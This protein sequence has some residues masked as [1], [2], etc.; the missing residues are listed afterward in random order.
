MNLE[1]TLLL[2][3]CSAATALPCAA[4]RP[5]PAGHGTCEVL[6]R[7]VLDA[8]PV[9]FSDA[10]FTID[11]TFMPN[12]T[13][14]QQAV[15]QQAV[16]EWTSR[17]QTANWAVNP[18]PILFQNGPL[19]DTTLAQAQPNWDSDG[20]LLGSVITIDND[21]T[22]TFF[23]DPTPWDDSE[24]DADGD[25]QSVMCEDTDLLTVIRHELGHALGWT[26]MFVSS[27]GAAANPK[28]STL[29]S[30]NLF[31]PTRFNI[32]FD[33]V[34]SNH[35]DEDVFPDSLMNPTLVPG[36]RQ[37]ISDY[38]V[39]S[40]M[41]RAYD[42]DVNLRFVAVGG[43]VSQ[44]GSADLPYSTFAYANQLAPTGITLVVIPGTYDAA[45]ATVLDRAHEIILAR[46]GSVI[47]K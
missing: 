8:P 27:N 26:G 33:P 44:A 22:S 46:G 11:V 13:A 47:L 31:D 20:V 25:C 38:P 5:V 30:G 24:F 40:M 19:G 41:A 17:L 14:A 34:P 7:L 35:T 42:Y 6:P 23:V 1:R 10:P 3:L 28:A 2:T 36:K 21:G 12:V 39:V 15:I 37:W 32:P 43:S 45:S 9:E 29:M 4:Q 18:Y 16:G